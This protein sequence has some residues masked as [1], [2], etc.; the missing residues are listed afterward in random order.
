[1]TYKN[2][3]SVVLGVFNGRHFPIARTNVRADDSF[4]DAL[5]RPC[6]KITRPRASSFTV[7]R[8]RRSESV[9]NPVPREGPRAR[10]A[11]ETRETHLDQGAR[12]RRRHPSRTLSNERTNRRA[13]V[14][15]GGCG[16]ADAAPERAFSA[17][18]HRGDYPI[19]GDEC[20]FELLSTCP[21][22]PQRGRGN[23]T[24]R[25]S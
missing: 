23:L 2:S 15:V 10:V 9:E 13:W 14:W 7:S 11:S 16:C 8:S 18:T 12:C 6:A 5:D 21:N 17:F 22:M 19:T 1:M 20:I 4:D 24:S 3:V 25:E